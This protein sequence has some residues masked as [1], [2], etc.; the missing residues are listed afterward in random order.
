ML[1]INSLEQYQSDY[2]RSIEN[3][4]LYSK[5]IAEIFE[6]KKQRD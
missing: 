3:L 4:E 5:G 2:K 6:W 1:K